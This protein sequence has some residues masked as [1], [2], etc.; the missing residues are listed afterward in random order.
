L[1]LIAGLCAAA[2]QKVKVAAMFVF[3]AIDTEVFPV[4]SVGRVVVMVVV[5]V[6]YGQQMHISVGELTAA[7]SAYPG[8]DF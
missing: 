7:A 1:S 6:M 5:L 8:V 4:A 3:M 2:L